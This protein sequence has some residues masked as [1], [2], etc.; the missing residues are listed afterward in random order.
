MAGISCESLPR[1]SKACCAAVKALG[2]QEM[3][4]LTTYSGLLSLPFSTGHWGACLHANGTR[5]YLV[6]AHRAG[7]SATSPGELVSEVGVCEPAA[8]GKAFAEDL[9]A[10]AGKFL[11]QDIVTSAAGAEDLAGPGFGTYLAAAAVVLLGLA[12]VVATVRRRT[13]QA[14]PALLGA[15]RLP[16]LVRAFDL[17]ENTQKLALPDASSTA[18]LNGVRVLSMVWIVLGH[19][20]LMA[21]ATAGYSNVED[22]MDPEYGAK[23]GFFFAFV[24]S[25][26]NAV[27]TFFFLSGYLLVL[28]S[29]SALAR[30]AG[31]LKAA[32]SLLQALAYRYLRLTP[33]LA[34]VM[35]CYTQLAFQLGN[36][37]FFPRHQVDITRR[38]GTWWTELLYSMNYYPWNSDDVCMGWTWYL[39]CEMIFFAFGFAVLL[40]HARAP[41]LGWAL[42][43]GTA[44]AS[45]VFVAYIT[46]REHLGIYVFGQ[47]YVDYTYWI[48]SKPH[49][50]IAAYIVGIG[51]ALLCP[52]PDPAQP[53][54]PRLLRGLR[55]GAAASVPLLLFIVGVATDAMRGPDA[56]G[57]AVSVLYI[58]LSR[59]AWAAA[60]ALISCACAHGAWPSLNR[61]FAWPG[62]SPLARLTYGCYLWHPVVVKTLASRQPEYYTYDVTLLLSRWVMNTVVAYGLALIL[63]LLV[64]RPCLTLTNALLGRAKR[65]ERPR[66]CSSG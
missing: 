20:F 13:A 45:T 47:P 60:W 44:A 43:A 12:A 64:E 32:L 48:Y 40:V 17:A 23:T 39:G 35:L 37:P 63:F 59:P 33:A 27:D 42:L 28:G 53:A 52:A 8:C 46:V 56:W 61:F 5:Y 7:S 16:L 29:R 18:C 6:S 66:E 21:G 36:G 57:P 24:V 10:V 11:G 55:W 22:I 2:E 41:R 4:R 50:R 62:F 58:A 26:Q 15:P 30:R 65:E 49:G 25:A 38:C 19:S 3:A 51:A 1:V 14:G 31:P 54:S 9:A 34:V